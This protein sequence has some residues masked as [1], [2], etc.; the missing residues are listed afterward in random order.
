MV[1]FITKSLRLMYYF[2]KESTYSKLGYKYIETT[3][4]LLTRS[5]FS[6]RN[7]KS[8]ETSI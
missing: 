1:D 4:Y 8:F 5:E 3:N 7:T 6:N 2:L